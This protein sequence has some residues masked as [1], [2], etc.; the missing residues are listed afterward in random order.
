M[1]ESIYYLSIFC[2]ILQRLDVHSL[3][4]EFFSQIILFSVI[5]DYLYV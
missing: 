1:S 4:C 2:K 5:M 3:S